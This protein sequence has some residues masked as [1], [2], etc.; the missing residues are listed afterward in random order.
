MLSTIMPSSLASTY[1][2]ESACH[3][4]LRC[5][6]ILEQA[7][8]EFVS[9]DVALRRQS[10]RNVALTCHAFL[11]PATALLWSD[12]PGLWP[13][14]RILVDIPEE[15]LNTSSQ[16]GPFP[17]KPIQVSH[18]A[19]RYNT[20]FVGT[21]IRYSL[22]WSFNK[23]KSQTP[24]PRRGEDFCTTPHSFAQCT[25]FPR[26]TSMRTLRKISTS[27]SSN[28]TTDARSYRCSSTLR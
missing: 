5:E 20:R 27:S 2:S 7:L 28:G 25:Y 19:H 9:W 17:S 26:R 11:H 14:Y 8:Q 24:S 15:R 21:H 6:E 23:I 22:F 4:A 10:F 3:R 12:P 16:W 1:T 13:L 18:S